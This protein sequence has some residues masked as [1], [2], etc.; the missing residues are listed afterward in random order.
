MHTDQFWMEKAYE[1]AL[2]A[3]SLNEVPVGAI[4]VL[5]NELIGAGFNQTRMNNDCTAH[6]EVV[7]LRQA[8]KA[9]SNYRL[10]GVTLYVTLEPCLMCLGALVHARIKRLVFA[11]LDPKS[12][13]VVSC[14]SFQ[15]KSYLNHKFE[16][17]H[18]VIDTKC[19]TLLK[20][21]FKAKR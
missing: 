15:E 10:P 4:V 7:A 20:N 9:C 8:T 17:E 5:D 18:G 21:F 2:K 6:A 16:I 3:S 11:A 14:E 19:A 12:G 13:A 1:Q